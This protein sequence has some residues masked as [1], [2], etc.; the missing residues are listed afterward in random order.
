MASFDEG[1]HEEI[2]V[3]PEDGNHDSGPKSPSAFAAAQN[4]DD[5]KDQCLKKTGEA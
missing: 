2:G 5:D 4:D 1:C 3:V